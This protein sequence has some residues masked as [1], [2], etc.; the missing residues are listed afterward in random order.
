MSAKH[1]APRS[2]ELVSWPVRRICLQSV[3]GCCFPPLP[4]SSAAQGRPT[5]LQPTPF[6]THGRS[7]SSKRWVLPSASSCPVKPLVALG[8]Q[9]LEELHSHGGFHIWCPF[10]RSL[11]F[12]RCDIFTHVVFAPLNVIL[13][14]IVHQEYSSPSHTCRLFLHA[15][16]T[17]FEEYLG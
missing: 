6:L 15:S 17:C 5:M 3:V 10:W 1:W 2:M 16:V 8:S 4:G 13:L 9:E 11:Q 7:S 14:R 12:D